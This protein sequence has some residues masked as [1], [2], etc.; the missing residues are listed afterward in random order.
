[1]QSLDLHPMHEQYMQGKHLFLQHQPTDIG[2]INKKYYIV[3]V[4]LNCNKESNKTCNA[5]CTG[6]AP[7]YRGNKLGCILTVPEI[8]RA[9][10]DDQ[11]LGLPEAFQYRIQ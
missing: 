1:M 8:Q 9:M 3:S 7:R 5:L 4:A 2:D 6:A 11:G 10:A